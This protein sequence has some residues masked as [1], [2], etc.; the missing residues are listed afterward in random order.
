MD[1]LKN[2]KAEQIQINLLNLVPV[3]NIEWER[4]EDGLV[5][6]LKPKFKHPFLMKHLL[7]RMKKPH[8]KIRLDDVGT[9]IWE[10]IDG[11]LTVRELAK[12]LKDKFGETVEPLYDRLAPFLQS[13]ERNR[14]IY[15]RNL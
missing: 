6:L 2:Q 4:N 9:F 13:L 1:L 3:R 12:S 7:P 5:V 8:Y 10:L 11:S 14:F 15:Y